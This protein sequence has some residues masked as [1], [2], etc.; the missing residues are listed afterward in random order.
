MMSLKLS[1]HLRLFLPN[2]L[3]PLDFVVRILYAF[4][5]SFKFWGFPT[6]G[7]PF[8][9]FQCAEPDAVDSVT[10]PIYCPIPI[11]LCVWQQILVKHPI[12]EFNENLFSCSRVVT[13]DRRTDS[14]GEANSTYELIFCNFQLLEH[15]YEVLYH[16]VVKL[17][18][19]H[20]CLC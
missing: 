1:S 2:G 11:K 10:C 6:Q 4:L 12:V 15:A 13:W 7:F 19:V 14:Q 18:L 5:I 20:I 8:R 16:A 9:A 3:F 17:C